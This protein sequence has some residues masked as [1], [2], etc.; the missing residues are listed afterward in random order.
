MP[1]SSEIRVVKTAAELFEAAAAEFAN[2]AAEAV[3][4]HGR[5]CVALS[6]GSTPR[7]LYSLLASGAIPSI[8]WDKIL[9]F[10]SDERHVPPDHPDS[11]F[12]MAREAMLSKVP[13]PAKHIFRILGEEKDAE[14]AALAYEETLRKVFALQPGE[15]P[16]FDLIL[17][18]LGTEGHTA[19]L[20]PGSPALNETKR[21]VAANW[22]E[23]LKTDRI[24]FTFPVLNHAACVMF[25]V[26]GA[27][28]A[29][30]LEQ[31]LETPGEELPAQRVHPANGR[32]FWLEDHA[33]AAKLS[34]ADWAAAP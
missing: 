27:D 23:K 29:E 13:V 32:L 14:A 4:A 6:G 1:A 20:F 33:A 8:P 2:L 10:W 30:I 12:R 24:T 21:L 3:R 15:F 31:I 22:V 17:L 18:G 7:G 16:R 34:D 28:K 25:L 5:F 19:S 26:S 9:F 11:N